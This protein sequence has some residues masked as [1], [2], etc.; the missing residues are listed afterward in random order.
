M[1]RGVAVPIDMDEVAERSASIDPDDAHCKTPMP[2]PQV[3]CVMGTYLRVRH[4]SIGN[5]CFFERLLGVVPP[6]PG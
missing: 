6:S 5:S 1:Y 3:T 4:E 2:F